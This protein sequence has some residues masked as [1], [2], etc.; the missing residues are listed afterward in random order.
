M[1]RATRRM[2]MVRSM[3]GTGVQIPS[4]Q[5]SLGEPITLSHP[6]FDWD[7]N[8]QARFVRRYPDVKPNA[9]VASGAE[10]SKSGVLRGVSLGRQIGVEP[11][12]QGQ[13]D[14]ELVLGSIATFL[15]TAL[16]PVVKSEKA[17][18]PEADD[19][20]ARAKAEKRAKSLADQITRDI[21]GFAKVVR[22]ENKGGDQCA[23]A[24][25][26]A[27]DPYYL[28]RATSWQGAGGPTYVLITECFAGSGV[29]QSGSSH[30]RW[31]DRDCEPRR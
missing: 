6:E 28:R 4:G 27:L 9:K 1:Q 12:G 8:T 30:T 3:F 22:T 25:A 31:Q 29:Y 26:E 19:A 18:L 23:A 11:M 17:D 7:N 15:G 2:D 16:R 10:P 24:N 5:W 20:D 14:A 21:P 13:P